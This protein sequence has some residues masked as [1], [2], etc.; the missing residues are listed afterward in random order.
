[1]SSP[2]TSARSSKDLSAGTEFQI[3]G[4]LDGTL[5]NSTVTQVLGMLGAAVGIN[6]TFLYPYSLLKKGWGKHHKKLARW[7]LGMTMFLPFVMVTSLVIIAMKVG[8]VYDG[9]DVVN[10]TM[11]PLEAAE[12]LSGVLGR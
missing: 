9:A 7:D 11:R 6:M 4:T 3:C 12:A 5:N 2:P 1:M 10:T 8:G